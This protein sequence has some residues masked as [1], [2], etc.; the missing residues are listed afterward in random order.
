VPLIEARWLA[1]RGGDPG[2]T[3]ARAESRLI[4]FVAR[5][6]ESVA[7][8][9]LLASCAIERAS[10]SRRKGI[11]PEKAAR[12]G[13]D[14][15]A[16]AIEKEPRDPV[17]WVLR[18]HLEALAGERAQ[19]RRSLEHAWAINARVKGGRESRRAEAAIA[20]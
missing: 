1:S 3:L 17:L 15:V 9:A 10:W 20:N 13:L 16:L 14:Q 11:H 12:A 5:H 4:P 18:A 8:R 6:H 19:A 2:K 7:G